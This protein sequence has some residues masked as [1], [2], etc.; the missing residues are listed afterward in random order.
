MIYW[1]LGISRDYLGN[2]RNDLLI[3]RDFLGKIGISRDF[4]T[5]FGI[6]K[7]FQIL[8]SVFFLGNSGIFRDFLQI[9]RNFQGFPRDYLGI[10]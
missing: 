8:K 4:F 7:D 9:F 1:F 6:S 3:F 5:D 2:F 10:S